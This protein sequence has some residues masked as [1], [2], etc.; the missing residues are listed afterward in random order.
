MGCSMSDVGC[1]ML[2]ARTPADSDDSS[3][4]ARATS[5]AGRTVIGTWNFGFLWSLELGIWC[6]PPRPPHSPIQRAPHAKPGFLHHVRVDLRRRHVLVSEQLLH[7]P[8]VI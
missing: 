4:A 2:D 5:S 1:W 8:D 3:P 7:R 6:L